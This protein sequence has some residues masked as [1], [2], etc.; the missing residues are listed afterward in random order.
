MHL[1]LIMYIQLVLTGLHYLSGICSVFIMWIM[2]YVN[3][4][5]AEEHNNLKNISTALSR[6]LF[7]DLLFKFSCESRSLFFLSLPGFGC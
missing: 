2:Y 3:F 5:S 4:I 6:T 1:G 7:L